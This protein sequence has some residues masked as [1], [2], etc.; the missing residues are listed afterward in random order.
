MRK[1]GWN[2]RRR[3]QGECARFAACGSADSQ[4]LIVD[5]DVGSK[6]VANE[7]GLVVQSQFAHQ[8]RLVGFDS[9]PT[10]GQSRG[11]GFVSMSFTRQLLTS[12]SREVS[13]S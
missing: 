8:V 9:A 12:R 5:E 2:L 11:N 13:N 7:T 3:K 10:D 4:L 6:R 1:A